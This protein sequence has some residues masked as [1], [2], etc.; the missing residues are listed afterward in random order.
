EVLNGCSLERLLKK[1]TDGTGVAPVHPLDARHCEQPGRKRIF[2]IRFGS[3]LAGK[4]VNGKFADFEVGRFMAKSIEPLHPSGVSIGR[5]K[6]H[7]AYTG[8]ALEFLNRSR[9][10]VVEQPTIGRPATKSA[11][12]IQAPTIGMK[13]CA[14]PSLWNAKKFVPEVMDPPPL[15]LPERRGRAPAGPQ[16]Q[17]RCAYCVPTDEF[18]IRTEIRK[19]LKINGR[20]GR[21][22]TGDPLTPSQVRY[23][24][25][26]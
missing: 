21:I 15:C 8:D 2:K 24:G 17:T 23:P 26:A 16:T 12:G 10:S 13:A 7:R 20:D 18:T 1:A 4:R 9:R 5:A 22:R 6:R 3:P 25:C 14:E 11:N 19:L